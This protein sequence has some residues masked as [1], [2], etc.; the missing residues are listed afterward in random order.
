MII[1]VVWILKGYPATFS[2]FPQAFPAVPVLIIILFIPLIFSYRNVKSVGDETGERLEPYR[3][4]SAQILALL[5]GIQ[6]VLQSGYAPLLP[7]YGAISGAA[8]NYYV[9]I[10][11]GEKSGIRVKYLS[12]FIDTHDKDLLPAP[13]LR[14]RLRT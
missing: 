12:C 8:V 2:N 13:F 5:F 9:S 11:P 10:L 14:E 4:I 3:V 1:I 7:L 6:L